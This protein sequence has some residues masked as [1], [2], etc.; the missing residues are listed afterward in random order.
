[1]VNDWAVPGALISTFVALPA[2]SHLHGLSKTKLIVAG[3]FQAPLRHLPRLFQATLRHCNRPWHLY[4]TALP[5]PNPFHIALAGYAGQ[6]AAE[7]IN[8]M[9]HELA[10]A[11]RCRRC[12]A[13]SV[14]HSSSLL[15]CSAG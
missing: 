5:Q 3:L 8:F 11:G 15:Q 14:T 6:H 2:V 4:P 1:M 9:M 10:T 7:A 12:I 13:P